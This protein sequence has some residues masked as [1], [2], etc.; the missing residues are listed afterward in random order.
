[1]NALKFSGSAY[2]RPITR[3]F[4]ALA[5]VLLSFAM[6]A[7]DAAARPTTKN[8]KSSD[9]QVLNFLRQTNVYSN[10]E[11]FYTNRGVDFNAGN[12][13][14]EGCFWPRGSGNSYIFGGGLWFAC[15]KEIQGKPH[16]LC[17]LGYNPNSGAGWYIEGEASQVGLTV[18]DSDAATLSSKYIS[19]VGPRYDKSSGKYISGSSSVVPSPTYAWP[20]WD[21]SSTKTLNHNYYFGDYISNVN[22]RNIAALQAANPLL[23]KINKLPAPALTSEEDILNLYTDQDPT[24]NPEYR[25]G[26]GYPFGIDIQEEIYSWSFGRYRDMIFERH[27][28]TNNTDKI[29]GASPDTLIDCWMAPAYDPDLDAAVGGAANDANSYVNDSLVKA[30][31]DPTDVSELREPYRSDAS[32]LNM[33]VQWRNTSTPPNGAQYGWLG[34]SFLE[35]P[36]I[37]SVGQIVANDDSVGLH[38]YCGPNSLFEKQPSVGSPAGQLGLVTFRDWIILNDPST[39]DL[40]YDFVSS[41]EK[42]IFNGDY[43]DQRLLMSTGPFTLPPGKS[44]ETVVGIGIAQVDNVDYKK[45]FG[46]LLLLMDF[47]H[48]VFGEVDSSVLLPLT[49]DSSVASIDSLKTPPDTTWSYFNDTTWSCSCNHFLSPT[50]PNIPTVTTTA[51]DKAVLVTWDSAAERTHPKLLVAPSLIGDTTLSFMGYQLWR[52]TRSDHD[53]TIRPDGNNPDVMLGQ[54]QLYSFT[55]DSV[56]DSKGHFNHL[57]YTRTSNVPNP[58]PHSYL[59]VGD[60]DHDGVLTGSEGLY[61]NVTYYYY[62]IAFN[63][64]DSINLVWTTLYSYCPTEELCSGDTEQAGLPRALQRRYCYE[65]RW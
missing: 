59:D 42:D 9:M 24:N 39:E 11:F 13:E 25:P 52:T 64:Y 45:N 30:D 53:S 41:G 38:G 46:A 62:V 27:K 8:N 18:G 6:S 49:P 48:E 44:V 3:H 65:R 2:S 28:V 55:A 20:L 34:F 47:A 12:G 36:V 14:A 15:K 63:E 50:S 10:I 60:D 22:N 29:P 1:M 17:E 33:G 23:G 40:R 4:I 56:F 37:D 32:K 21:T 61:N 26:T 5:A 31:A 43:Q 19:Y 58:I 35:S 51:L 57:H 7:Q 54:W 16:K